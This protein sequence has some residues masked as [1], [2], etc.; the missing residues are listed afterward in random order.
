[1]SPL[2]RAR[3]MDYALG[4]MQARLAFGE[5]QISSSEAVKDL[6]LLQGQ[7]AKLGFKLLHEGR[8]NC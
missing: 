7:A 3:A 5:T 1:M 4:Q 6:E 8:R 2:E